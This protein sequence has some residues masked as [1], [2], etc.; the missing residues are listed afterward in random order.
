MGGPVVPLSVE[1]AALIAAGPDKIIEHAKAR[2][3]FPWWESDDPYEIA[4]RQL[5]ESTLLVPFDRLRDA[6]GLV[7]GREVEAVE[8]LDCASLV[9]EIDGLMGRAG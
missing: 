6:V 5:R 4:N 9:A 1:S 8:F 2:Y 3:C 7:L